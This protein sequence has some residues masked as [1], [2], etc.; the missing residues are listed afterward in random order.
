MHQM[1]RYVQ[2]GGRVIVGVCFIWLTSIAFDLS[3]ILSEMKALFRNGWILLAM[4]IAYLSAFLLRAKAWQM[5][6]NERMPFK[7]FVDGLFYS[8]FLNHLL[9]IKAGDLIRTGYLASSNQVSW[10]SALESVIIMR[11]LDLMILGFIALAG[12]FYLGMSI[13]YL[14]MIGLIVGGAAL[15]GLLLLK[16]KW[17]K[18]IFSQAKHAGSIIF[19]VKGIVLVLLIVVSWILEAVIVIAVSTQFETTLTFLKSIWV[20]SF[21][22]AGQ[23]FHFSPGGIGTYESFM[24]FGL[25]AFQV[26]IKEAYTIAILT[27]GYKFIFSFVIGF[28]LILSAPISWTTIKLWMK[29]KED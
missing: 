2:W 24:S 20:N 21:T 13:S 15:L 25:R 22:I 18:V 9:P 16:E 8:L 7:H 6:V 10:K 4:T 3:Y 23:V 14:F 12:V 28:Y 26:P 5:Y 19:S 1:K 11:I 27:H 17:R 29:R